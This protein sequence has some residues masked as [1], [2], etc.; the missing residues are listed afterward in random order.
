MAF[1]KEHWENIYKTKTPQQVS[2]TQ[3]VPQTSLDCFYRM[4]LPKNA[5]VIDVGAG[6]S[7]FV[8]F[9]IQSGYYNISVL[10]ISAT[11]LEKVKERLGE[12]AK[13]VTWIASDIIEFVPEFSYSFWHDRAVFHFLTKDE[14]IQKYISITEQ[15]IQKNGILTIGTFSKTGPLKCSG[16]EIKQYDEK[17]LTALFAR[18]FEKIGCIHETHTTPFDTRQDFIFCQFR[19]K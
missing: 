13:T 10:D 17:T 19:K 15:Y 11:A 3:D 9:L 4:E 18:S 8:D 14:E 6:E 2:W 12:N 7:K 1:S 16:L 5:T